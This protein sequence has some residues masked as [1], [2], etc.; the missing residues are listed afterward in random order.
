MR[1][2]VKSACPR[3]WP[4]SPTVEVVSFRLSPSSR[5]VMVS[6][7]F[8]TTVL[9]SASFCRDS[10]TCIRI[11]VSP[12]TFVLVTGT[13]LP[14]PHRMLPSSC[15][16]SS[17]M[18][19]QPAPPPGMVNAHRPRKGF[20]AATADVVISAT[21]LAMNARRF[22]REK[23]CMDAFILRALQCR[24][25]ILGGH[26]QRHNLSGLCEPQHWYP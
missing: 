7:L 2:P 19:N 13:T 3:T 14:P 10:F 21:A 22:A 20:S 17:L 12:S 6:V 25:E 24:K 16:P 18:P 23:V 11:S 1:L 8:F 9:P 5:A 15:P 4:S 26:G